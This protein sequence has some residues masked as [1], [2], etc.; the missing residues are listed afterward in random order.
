MGRYADVILPL[1]LE[2]TYTYEVPEGMF[3]EHGSRVFVQFGPRKFY[4]GIVSRVHDNA[5]RGYDV[6]RIIMVMDSDTIVRYPQVKFWQWLADYYLCSL[7]EV[8]KAAVPSGLKIESET[9]VSLRDDY[10]DRIEDF[11]LSDSEVRVIQALDSAKR[12]KVSELSEKGDIRYPAPVVSKLVEKGLVATDELAMSKYRSKRV[13]MVRLAFECNDEN[14][15]AAFDNVKRSVRQERLLIMFLD[16]SGAMNGGGS[17]EVEKNSLLEKAGVS[18]AVLKGLVDKGILEVFK[19]DVNRFK[20]EVSSDIELTPLSSIQYDAKESIRHIWK[21]KNVVL[22]RGVTGSGKTE[23]YSHL[24]SAALEGGRQVLYLVPEISLTTQLTSRLRK[25]FG[26]RLMVYHSRFSDNERVDLWKKML[27]SREPMVVLGAR[28]S[29]FLPFSMLGLVI[30]DEE[31]ESSYKQFDPAP[32]YN[33]RDAAILLATMH[34][35]KVLL[36]SATPS[37]E[38]YYKARTGKYG[39]VELLERHEGGKMPSIEIVDMKRQRQ[40]KENRGILSSTLYEA[41]RRALADGQQAIM[42]Q[43]RRGFAPMVVC[44][45]CG[46][47]PKCVNCDVS[48]VYHKGIGQLRCHYCGYSVPLPKLCP[49]CGQNAIEIYGYGTER[50][51]EELEANFPDARIQR[52]DLDTTR[53][54]D[55]YQEII[56]RFSRKE[57]DILTGTQMVSK[58]LDFANVRIVGVMNADTLLHYPDFRSRERAFNMLVQV[59][60]RAGRRSESGEVIVQTTDPQN[61]V[62]K[63]VRNHNFEGFY[64]EEIIDREKY[65][66]PPFS[67]VI[68]IYLKSKDERLLSDI[69]VKYAMSLRS[70][71]GERVLGPERPGVGRI[72]TYYL[73]TVMLKVEAEASMRKV[74][75]LLRRVYAKLADDRRLRGVTIYYDVDPA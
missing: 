35:A 13:S 54:K 45:E 5:P 48:L 74:K 51:A 14:L 44:N 49:A 42:F 50:I 55:A 4:T 53:N 18:G 30:V 27:K 16:M 60:G 20:T 68:N 21:D 71:L 2:G 28:S 65:K 72:A 39:L 70:L 25:M 57:T 59:A 3:V 11:A 33:A 63:Y 75:D 52:M 43:N 8:Y 56:D 41:T 32:R 12:L 15:H 47:A 38:T 1:P 64:D 17:A 36:G 58:G 24:I 62:L 6:K 34:D 73:Q 22:L 46:W 66:Y 23:I 67:R 19:K 61:E 7:G 26:D 40:R 31:H 37:V 10:L 29:V 69:A 9:Y